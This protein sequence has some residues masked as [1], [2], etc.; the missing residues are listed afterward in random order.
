M[1]LVGEIANQPRHR[2]CVRSTR[3]DNLKSV[4]SKEEGQ[5]SEYEQVGIDE[6]YTLILSECESN[7]LVD[8]RKECHSLLVQP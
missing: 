3:R 7:E 8:R 1:Q 5:V 2:P 4:M 6:H